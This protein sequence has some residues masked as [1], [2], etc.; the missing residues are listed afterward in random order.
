[1]VGF[2]THGEGDL[3]FLPRM[4]AVFIPLAIAWFLLAP[5]FRLFQPEITSSPKQLWRLI[6][7]MFFAT[8]F[9]VILRGLILN[10][11]IIPI[12]AIVL[13]AVSAFGMLIW[14]GIYL[15][16]SRSLRA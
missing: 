2:A 11:A 9:A 1:M 15:L 14:R 10:A 4:F 12:F 5:W 3:S 7:V 6:L 16:Y 8:P 13:S